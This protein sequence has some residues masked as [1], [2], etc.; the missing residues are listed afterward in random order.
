MISKAFAD[1][2]LPSRYQKS[3]IITL[4]KESKRNYSLTSSYHPISLKN[5]LAKIVE[6]V[7]AIRLSRA[8]EEHALLTW[9]QIRARKERSMM[10]AIGLLTSCVQTA[11]RA[12]PGSVVSML[13]L[14]LAGT[15]DNVPHD[16]LLRILR[17]KR[18]PK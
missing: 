17:S 10:S 2:T 13:N 5:T 7:L 1:G 15:F 3:V 18:M 14:D 16:K 12:K 9:T 8:A 11:W 6:K 4:R